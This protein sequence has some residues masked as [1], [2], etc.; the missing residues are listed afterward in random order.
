MLNTS[1]GLLL[2]R[3]LRRGG[4]Q[5]TH[6]EQ[7]LLAVAQAV[8]AACI[9]WPQAGWD[10]VANLLSRPSLTPDSSL[11]DKAAATPPCT[12]IES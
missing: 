5:L 7:E 12:A 1:Q 4:D 3:V 2:P 6:A 9:P 8:R 10:A 11:G